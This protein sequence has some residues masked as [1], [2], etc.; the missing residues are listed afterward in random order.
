[1]TTIHEMRPIQIFRFESFCLDMEFNTVHIPY[2]LRVHNFLLSHTRSSTFVKNMQQ[3]RNTIGRQRVCEREREWSICL[4]MRSRYTIG[5]SVQV[6]TFDECH[7]D[8]RTQWPTLQSLC[9]CKNVITKTRNCSPA[10]FTVGVG[11][12]IL[13]RVIY[14][15]PIYT[16]KAIW[17]GHWALA[18]YTLILLQRF[19]VMLASTLLVFVT[20]FCWCW[21]IILWK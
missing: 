11:V 12:A 14:R 20:V 15:L 3:C 1:M 18:I 6:H 7:W 9:H 13:Y 16:Q 2:V 21:R 17:D 4:V 5:I 19:S 10:V 8:H